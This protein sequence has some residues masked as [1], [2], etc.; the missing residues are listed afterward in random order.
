MEG[1]E[2]KPEITAQNKEAELILKT[3]EFGWVDKYG[4]PHTAGSLEELMADVEA[5]RED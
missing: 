1:K 3:G 2:P 4:I 5:H